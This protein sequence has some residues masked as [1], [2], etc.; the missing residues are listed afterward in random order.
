MWAGDA[1]HALQVEEREREREEELAMQDVGD[2]DSGLTQAQL[3]FGTVS[4][5][6]CLVLCDAV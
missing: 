2:N 5:S 6:C 4:L 1:A 3:I